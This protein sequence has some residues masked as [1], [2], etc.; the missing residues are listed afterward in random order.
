MSDDVT[1]IRDVRTCREKQDAAIDRLTAQVGLLADV[2]EEFL[3]ELES[4]RAR[5]AHLE[6]MLPSVHPKRRTAPLKSQQ[7]SAIHNLR[8]VTP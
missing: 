5:I 8:E 3:K 7:L 6:S 4:L 1:P 2:S